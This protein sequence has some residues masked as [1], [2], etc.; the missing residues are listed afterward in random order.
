MLALGRGIG[1]GAAVV[2]LALWG[3][4]LSGNLYNTAGITAATYSVVY[5]MVL[6][7][8]VGVLAAWKAW[9]HLMLLVFALSFI[10]MGFYLLG[11]PGVFFWIGVA[12]LGFLVS[13]ILL[14]KGRRA[15]APEL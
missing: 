4:F 5:L 2:T 12:N 10:P 11:T 8:V 15:Q 6:I 3:W 14:R 9:P 13:G 7:A 1:L